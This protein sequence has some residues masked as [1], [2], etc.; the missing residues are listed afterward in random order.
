VADQKQYDL[1]DLY[2]R[3]FGQI[4][5]PFPALGVKTPNLLPIGAVKAIASQYQKKEAL[6]PVREV[7]GSFEY[8]GPLNATYM[9]PVKL[10]GRKKD[11]EEFEPGIQLWN[12]PLV[13]IA[14][15]KNIITTA[16]AGF[17]ARNGERRRGSVKELVSI[18]DYSVRIRGVIQ[19]PDNDDVYPKE[20]VKQFRYLVEQDILRID[21]LLTNLFGIQYIVVQEFG[22][23]EIEGYP[24]LQPYEIM[25]LSDEPFD[26]GTVKILNP[27]NTIS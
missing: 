5:I 24:G 23:P 16:I 2:F 15:R 4:G 27:I 25:A 18:E 3:A 11:S 8:S 19:N 13:S 21:C 10:A 7:D 1:R 12:E 26:F 6:E 9:M 17:Q 14:G 20:Q 22:L